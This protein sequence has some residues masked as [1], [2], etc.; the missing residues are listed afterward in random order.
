MTDNLTKT[1]R[2]FSFIL[3]ILAVF[4][5]ASYHIEEGFFLF[6]GFLLAG[7]AFFFY[8]KFKLET[9]AVILG[10]VPSAF[11]FNNFKINF[12]FLTEGL[13][14]SSFPID[15]RFFLF[16][17]LFFIFLI[18]FI[19]NFR[20]FSR[21]PLFFPIIA[22]GFFFS[23]SLIW[24]NYP[25]LSLSQIVIFNVPF[26]SYLLIFFLIQ[27]PGNFLRLLFILVISSLPVLLYSIFQIIS[28]DFF[29][30]PDSSLGRITGTFTHPNLL[31]LYLFS[32]ASIIFLGLG[33]V[34]FS[35]GSN[36]KR[37]LI[38]ISIL[39]FPIFMLTFSR[40]AWI[41]LSLFLAVFW[42]G[43]WRYFKKMILGLMLFGAIVLVYQPV[44]E[45]ITGMFERT[46]FDSIWAR[47]NI[48]RFGLEKFSEKPLW[49][50]GIGT[51]EE[52]VKDA[53]E[54]DEGSSF[55]HNDVLMV[56]LEG[57]IP[58]ALLFLALLGWIFIHFT[59]LWRKF[60][61][62]LLEELFWKEKLIL[63][64]KELSRACLAISFVI[65]VGGVVETMFLKTATMLI[66]FSILG[67]VD[68]MLGNKNGLIKQ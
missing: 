61:D 22:L 8:P 9:T 21:A 51:F 31:G 10:L 13:G 20:S 52:I 19:S 45:R 49:G 57:G 3:G 12:S 66:F 32:I 44:Q 42:S 54:S 56:A 67:A 53:K 38:F 16:L 26:V 34:N 7:V 17:L 28:G 48:F 4:S 36:N 5:L 27:R 29:F 55:P 2:I 64:S 14:I 11:L 30:E 65:I 41:L 1:L 35:P 33:S 63:H 18:E 43:S 23:L 50:Y 46:P 15:L 37:I 62:T 39:L 25:S 68:G 60:S 58:S 47:E 59:L 24:S 40:T 6:L